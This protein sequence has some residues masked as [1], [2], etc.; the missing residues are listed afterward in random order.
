MRDDIDVHL[1]TCEACARDLA[2]YREV[3]AAVGSLRDH[4]EEPPAGMVHRIT[5]RVLEPERRLSDR[6][7]RAAKDRRVHVAAASFGGAVLGAGAIVVL[8]PRAARRAAAA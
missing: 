6:L 5:A 7:R 2:R 3:T 4:F 8:W 1:A